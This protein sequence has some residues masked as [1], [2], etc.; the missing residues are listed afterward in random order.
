MRQT[1][2]DEERRIMAK[3]AIEAVLKVQSELGKPIPSF[4]NMV[5]AVQFVLDGNEPDD[6]N[7]RAVLDEL[8]ESERL[9]LIKAEKCIHS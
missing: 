2:T 8:A 6:S 4:K 1:Y 9:W 5:W 3:A 7:S